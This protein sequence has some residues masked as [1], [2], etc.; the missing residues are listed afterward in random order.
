MQRRFVFLENHSLVTCLTLPLVTLR[1]PIIS[2]CMQSD[3]HLRLGIRKTQFLYHSLTSPAL[4][5]RWLTHRLPLCSAHL[6]LCIMILML[7]TVEETCNQFFEHSLPPPA[8]HY[9]WLAQR[10]PIITTF[11]L[12]DPHLRL[13]RRNHYFF[14]H[15]SPSP[16][17]HCRRLTPRV[18]HGP[19][20]FL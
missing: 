19:H 17:L 8:L 7:S 10:L 2:T 3:P 5:Y 9:R 16:V 18:P 13:G 12:I 20:A 6:P 14:E 11:M 4:H 15:S 1:L